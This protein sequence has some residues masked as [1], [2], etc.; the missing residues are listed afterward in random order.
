[1]ELSSESVLSIA[2]GDFTVEVDLQRAGVVTWVP[3]LAVW[4]IGQ[5]PMPTVQ[6]LIED[7]SGVNFVEPAKTKRITVRVKPT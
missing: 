2:V 4:S 7:G 1:M 5:S 3:N 6:M